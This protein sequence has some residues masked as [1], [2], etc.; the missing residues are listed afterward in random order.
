MDSIQQCNV[1]KIAVFYGHVA[2]NLG[3]LAINAGELI[4]LKRIY[5]NAEVTFVALHVS[6]GPAYDNAQA[7]TARVGESIWTIYRTSFHHA[8]NYLSQPAQFLADCGVDDS[9]LVVLASGEHLFAYEKNLNIRALYWRTLPALAAKAAG[10]RC[11]LLP[12]TFG[13]F[14]TDV[15]KKWMAALFKIVDGYA[16]R[17]TGSADLLKKEFGL[18]PLQLPDPAFFIKP[19]RVR[20]QSKTEITVLGL[21]MRAEDWGIRLS[22]EQRVDGHEASETSDVG[23]LALEFAVTAVLEFFAK[24]PEGKVRMFVQTVADQL[25]AERVFG[26]L[27]ELERHTQVQVIMPETIPD[28][29][30]ALADVDVLI[31]ARF[32]ALIMGLIAHV[33]VYGVYFPVHGHKIPGLFS[34]LG[35]NSSCGLIENNVSVVASD[36]VERLLSSSFNWPV[37]DAV[38]HE[39]RQAFCDWIKDT[40]VVDVVNGRMFEASLVLNELAKELIQFGFKQEKSA[41]KRKLAGKLEEELELKFQEWRREADAE[42]LKEREELRNNYL[43][44][45]ENERSLLRSQHKKNLEEERVVLRA[46]ADAEQQRE[47]EELR[48]NYLEELESE[49][50]FLRSQH[51]KGMEEQRVMLRAQAD[52]EQQS[53]REEL[54]KQH[55]EELEAERIL[56]RSQYE[57]ELDAERVVL[58]T[59]SEGEREGQLKKHGARIE[60][61]KQEQ[62]LLVDRLKRQ[63]EALKKS[64]AAQIRKLQSDLELLSKENAQLQREAAKLR[65]QLGILQGS[66]SYQVAVEAARTLR[67]R[68]KLL[69]LPIRLYTIYS[70]TQSTRKGRSTLAADIDS[71]KTLESALA[72][73]EMNSVSPRDA[74]AELIKESKALSEQGRHA[75]ACEVA[76]RALELSRSEATLRALFWAQQ[77]G[78]W[79]EDAFQTVREL[80]QYLGEKPSLM[81]KE[82][83]DI[84]RSQPS[85][86]LNLKSLLPTKAAGTAYEPLKGRLAYVLHNSLPFSSG[87]YATRAQGLAKGLVAQGYE[88]VAFT[89][90]GY[91]LDVN[92][93]LDPDS[94]PEVQSIDGVTYVRTFEPSRKRLKM[95]EFIPIATDMMAAHF[96]QYKPEVVVAAS[97]YI[98][99]M[100]ALFAA[101]R[102]G[103]PFVYEVRGFWEITRLSREP[104][105][106]N[107]AA[108][109]IQE[110]M[111]AFVCNEADK[112]LTLTEAMKVELIRRG[113]AGDKIEIVPNACEPE[114]FEPRPRDEA[115][116]ARFGIPANVAVIGYVG[117]FVDYEGLDDLA[118]A[119]GLL[120]RQ[121]REFRLLLVGNENVSGA[122]RGPISQAVLDVAAEHNFVDWLI[123]PGRVPHEDVAAYYSLIDIAPFPRKPWPVCEMVSPMKPLEA[124]AMEKTVVVSSVSALAEMAGYGEFGVIFEKG[125]TVSLAEALAKIL[126]NPSLRQEL[127]G[128]GRKHVLAERTWLRSSQRFAYTLTTIPARAVSAL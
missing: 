107:H 10:K 2:S 44:E 62:L 88:V 34:W 111:E 71:G 93:A 85:F 20:D 13:P 7:E 81:Q 21:A 37:V 114:L 92:N 19:A 70:E 104:E 99:A 106:I 105:F 118:K 16:A 77:N 123:M 53:E 72:S 110:L 124:M 15:S 65:G 76:F 8:L 58:R 31:A 121:G 22:K 100:P 60:A 39:G 30:D 117:T 6:E 52:A 47:R 101:R 95:Q 119:C 18:S 23:E 67:S 45:L 108:Y 14:E 36:A 78:G 41:H 109:K 3:D 28:Y 5:P 1:N 82:R 66:T 50:D 12:S 127:G 83:M 116:A 26:R 79:V 68:R 40:P 32:H 25:L 9:D 35:L 91:P 51:E 29:L 112:V 46:Q 128:A 102:L 74:A 4:A 97:N 24:K 73:I 11:L 42:Q 57:K 90:P 126:A 84:I 17:E 69:S 27:Q 55:F 54:H 64:S 103:L 59:Q 125:C 86:Q 63:H 33:P 89:R 75:D 43:E 120:R 61:I 56:L 49:R 80:Q 98:C 115:L 113:V 48:N 38:I 122:E 96:M 94:V 87:G